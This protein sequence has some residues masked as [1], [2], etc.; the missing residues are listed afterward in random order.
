MEAG[1]FSERRQR[2][3]LAFWTFFALMAW[4]WTKLLKM[5]L[6]MN[7][8]VI[9]ESMEVFSIARQVAHVRGAFWE[10]LKNWDSLITWG[11][12]FVTGLASLF[13]PFM[14]AQESGPWCGGLGCG[15][16]CGE[17]RVLTR[18]RKW[19]FFRLSIFFVRYFK[20]FFR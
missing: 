7:G 1:P 3:S 20:L 16:G 13:P 18:F 10:S 8:L 6:A 12:L 14:L 17:S 15:S 19:H 4:P 9:L 5:H 11:S 2:N